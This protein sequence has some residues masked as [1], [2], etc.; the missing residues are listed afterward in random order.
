MRFMLWRDNNNVDNTNN[1]KT[2]LCSYFPKLDTKLNHQRTNQEHNKW[3]GILYMTLVTGSPI[4][5]PASARC[6]ILNRRVLLR[7]SLSTV[8]F[9]D[10]VRASSCSRTAL[11][12]HGICNLQFIT[13]IYVITTLPGLLVV[14]P[15]R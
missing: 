9:N 15:N 4:N 2:L 10:D 8:L 7:Y 1:L 13:T 14:W 5:H 11:Y 12:F 6:L 3:T